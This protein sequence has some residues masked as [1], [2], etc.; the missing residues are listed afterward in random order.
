MYRALR[1]KHRLLNRCCRL[2]EPF[3]SNTWLSDHFGIL[4]ELSLQ[5]LTADP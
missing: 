2:A 1:E 4:T 5:P 3:F